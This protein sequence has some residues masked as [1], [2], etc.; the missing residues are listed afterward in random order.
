MNTSIATDFAAIAARMKSVSLPDSDD[1]ELIQRY[2]RY[3][4]LHEAL[5][6]LSDDE[7]LRQVLVSRYGECWHNHVQRDADPD[8]RELM[9]RAEE[10]NTLCEEYFELSCQIMA[11]RA[12]SREGVLA[13]LRVALN[14]WPARR[15]E[16][17]D[18]ECHEKYSHTAMLDAVHVLDAEERRP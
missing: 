12:N 13:K 11:M 3:A 10:A 4:V 6:K 9:R 1:A 8:Y 18:V 7:Q 5:E 14:E 2:R 16:E 17:D 15:L